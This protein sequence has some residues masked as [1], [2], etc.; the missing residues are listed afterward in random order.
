MTLSELVEEAVR[1]RLL[2]VEQ[3]QEHPPL[4]TFK[5]GGLQPGVDLSSNAAIQELLDEGL[6]LD[7]LR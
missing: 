1:I 4:P 6:P 3:A 2:E 7:Q 5:S